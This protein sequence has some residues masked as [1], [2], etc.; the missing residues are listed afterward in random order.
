MFLILELVRGGELFELI[1]SNPS[2][3]SRSGKQQKEDDTESIMRKFFQELASGIAYCHANGIAH[4]DLK[5][6]NLLVHNGPGDERTLKIADF[7]LSA[8][9][10]LNRE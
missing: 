2:A 9:F 6:E 10:A 3:R 7:G 8:T 1:S 5:P 4:R